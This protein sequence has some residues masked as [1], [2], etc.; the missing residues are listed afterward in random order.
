MRVDERVLSTLKN[1]NQISS[2]YVAKE[3]TT[4]IEVAGFFVCHHPFRGGHNHDAQTI[5]DARNFACSGKLA[6]AW[7]ADAY[8]FADDWLF[9]NRIV[10]QGYFDKT[11]LV[12]R[13]FFF[14]GV[15]E[16]IP[17]I[18]QDFRHGFLDARSRNLDDAVPRHLR[19]ADAGEIVCYRVGDV[20]FIKK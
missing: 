3:L 15:F 5:D 2:T 9:G 8:E 14:E 10:L 17:L 13:R 1:L 19:I 20:H 11:L 4:Y 16:N 12:F 6:Q 7:T 18:I